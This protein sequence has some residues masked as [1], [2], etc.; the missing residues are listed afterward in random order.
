MPQHSTHRQTDHAARDGAFKLAHAIVVYWYDRG[1]TV[2]AWLEKREQD[3][4][5][6]VYSV[7]TDLVGGQPK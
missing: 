5:K 6:L 7:Q 2:S 4:G 1:A 3:G